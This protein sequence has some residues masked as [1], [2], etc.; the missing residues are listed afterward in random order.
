MGR[1]DEKSQ[2]ALI[3]ADNFLETIAEILITNG[4]SSDQAGWRI[5]ADVVCDD[6]ALGFDPALRCA[7]LV[8]GRLAASDAPI[9]AEIK[10]IAIIFWLEE[11]LGAWWRGRGFEAG[12]RRKSVAVVLITN[13]AGAEQS[14]WRGRT[15]IIGYDM[16]LG[17]FESFGDAPG[18][19]GGLATIN[20]PVEA[21]VEALTTNFRIRKGLG[22]G[23]G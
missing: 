11:S 18:I 1:D 15:N 6:V 13:G 14:G 3:L 23:A 17:I 22:F 16:A 20:A 5:T 9:D 21:K 19:S 12:N 7:E 8:S 2:I 10:A 4:T